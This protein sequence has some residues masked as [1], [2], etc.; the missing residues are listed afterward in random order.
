MEKAL[1]ICKEYCE[2]IQQEGD[3]I[4]ILIQKKYALDLCLRLNHLHF[5]LTEKK[6]N[7]FMV[8]L[9]FCFLPGL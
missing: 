6:E 4:K 7:H 2:E 8:L 1:D 9:T 3:C 5:F